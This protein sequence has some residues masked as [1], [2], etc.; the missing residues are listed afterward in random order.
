MVDAFEETMSEFANDEKLKEGWANFAEVYTAIRAMHNNGEGT[1]KGKCV[2]LP[3]SSTLETVDVLQLSRSTAKSKFVT[4]D[5]LSVKKGKGGASALTSKI[6]K[7][8]MID[9]DDGTKKNRIL[10]MSKI[11]Y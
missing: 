2:L 8:V 6:S 3:E 5:G 10:K 1:E 4:L 9:D 7:A 11:T